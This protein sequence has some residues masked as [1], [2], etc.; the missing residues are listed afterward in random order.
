MSQV[1]NSIF[2]PHLDFDSVHWVKCVSI[3]HIR[4][5]VTDIRTAELFMDPAEKTDWKACCKQIASFE[6][7][8]GNR[9]TIEKL[10]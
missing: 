8:F 2:Y 1:I 4:A 3:S 10:L 9:R 5:T 6:N 7:G